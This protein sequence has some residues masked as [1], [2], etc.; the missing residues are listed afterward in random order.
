MK[1]ILS[2]L[3][4]MLL[5]TS[6]VF[7]PG[8]SFAS[9]SPELAA[10][11]ERVQA[12]QQQRLNEQNESRLQTERLRIGA[13]S[14]AAE[15][16]AAREAG[17]QIPRDRALVTTGRPV[18]TGVSQFSE[19][20]T[21]ESAAR[22]RALLE[23]NGQLK[24]V[25]IE[26]AKNTTQRGLPSTLRNLQNPTQSLGGSSARMMA[27]LPLSWVKV[28]GLVGLYMCYKSVVDYAHSPEACLMFFSKATDP[29]MIAQFGA[30]TLTWQALNHSIG[31]KGHG[32]SR[33]VNH[34]ARLFGRESVPGPKLGSYAPHHH[35]AKRLVSHTFFL[36]AAYAVGYGAFELM[37]DPNVKFIVSSYLKSRTYECSIRE[38][39]GG[40]PCSE[41]DIARD[42]A[43]YKQ[44]LDEAWKG[45]Y[46]KF[47]NPEKLNNIDVALTSFAAAGGIALLG[48]EAASRTIINRKLSEQTGSIVLRP[49]F[50]RIPLMAGFVARASL[51]SSTGFLVIMI[52]V[53]FYVSE[54]ATNVIVGTRRKGEILL[55]LSEDTKTLSQE[56]GLALSQVRS[57]LILSA[58]ENDS[59]NSL[60]QKLLSSLDGIE[61]L[62]SEPKS[63]TVTEKL[64][65]TAEF[66]KSANDSRRLFLITPF[67]QAYSQW[68][69]HIENFVSEFIT[70]HDYYSDVLKAAHDVKSKGKTLAQYIPPYYP[71]LNIT[72][73][74][75]GSQTRTI[76]IF[77]AISRGLA[78]WTTVPYLPDT[79]LHNLVELHK[80]GVMSGPLGILS[81][82]IANVHKHSRQAD[83]NESGRIMRLLED[84]RRSLKSSNDDNISA[85]RYVLAAESLNKTNIIALMDSVNTLEDEGKTLSEDERRQLG[86]KAEREF[87]EFQASMN[88]EL[89]QDGAFPAI[90]GTALIPMEIGKATDFWGTGF[91]IEE[92]G[93][94]WHS[95]AEYMTLRILC[96]T[97]MTEPLVTR[98]ILGRPRFVAPRIGPKAEFC[99]NSKPLR[100]VDKIDVNGRGVD[101]LDILTQQLTQA[102]PHS[103]PEALNS[104]IR[105]H[106]TQRLETQGLTG[107]L[108]FENM[109]KKMTQETLQA[110]WQD[111]TI[112]TAKSIWASERAERG[113]GFW[114]GYW[115]SVKGFF[116]MDSE[117][118]LADEELLDVQFANG[119]RRALLI[120]ASYFLKSTALTAFRTGT[121]QPKSENATRLKTALLQIFDL[122]ATRPQQLPEII[123]QYKIWFTA[124]TT[125]SAETLQYAKDMCAFEADYDKCVE[126]I[127]SAEADSSDF[128]KVS[129]LKPEQ[130]HAKITEKLFSTVKETLVEGE[131]DT[132]LDR[133]FESQLT[134]VLE[135]SQQYLFLIKNIENSRLVD[136]FQ[137]RDKPGNRP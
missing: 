128:K 94:K 73:R 41:Q 28:M 52:P 1:P 119:L 34:A 108:E 113:A 136:P 25:E 17:Q 137:L 55:G 117:D 13:D 97:D 26:Q 123:E 101:I 16:R 18:I 121:V 112:E 32:G 88:S 23:I 14:L 49:I 122:M 81:S 29:A 109:Y 53:Y 132:A 45:V 27:D 77:R 57:S 80:A 31:M 72:P 11:R 103:R 38:A 85:L 60:R 46:E 102:V 114:T 63:G 43:L 24:T 106:L 54:Y 8:Y 3:T 9:A 93:I 36:A 48:M 50:A 56:L 59:I 37:S 91:S 75:Q 71:G 65:Q 4:H 44:S 90:G 47:S 20:V 12:L 105:T 61:T 67:L 74:T 134:G 130:A 124:N 33:L 96:G 87:K 40:A 125:P 127:L 126:G 115:R 99:T 89:I 98:R 19:V 70:V 2:Q 135:S 30:M 66:L 129:A 39:N 78:R 107:A 131:T 7:T 69:T 21:D 42:K 95:K 100:V 58:D 22:H 120:D 64:A 6:L 51:V 5:A 86:Q 76:L 92:F 111:K 79:V 118:G 82:Y 15:Q 116:G 68:V 110:R 133:A 83:Y 84:A 35:F 104:W 10:Q 62:A